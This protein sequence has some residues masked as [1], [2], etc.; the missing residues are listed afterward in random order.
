MPF[1]RQ[2]AKRSIGYGTFTKHLIDCVS[3]CFRHPPRLIPLD[4]VLGEACEGKTRAGT[5]HVLIPHPS[6]AAR[7]L[8]WGLR[9]DPGA[10]GAGG[11]GPPRPLFTDMQC[12]TRLPT[13]RFFPGRAFIFAFRGHDRSPCDIDKSGSGSLVWRG[14]LVWGHSP[15]PSNT[16]PTCLAHFFFLSCFHVSR[17]TQESTAAPKESGLQRNNQGI[18][19]GWAASWPRRFLPFSS[20][21]LRP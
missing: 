15:G 14:V 6:P 10:R 1:F 21:L 11:T 12:S 13:G 8:S 4:R 7:K 18:F 16:P 19:W 5:W 9:G 3:H 2:L 20:F 17:S